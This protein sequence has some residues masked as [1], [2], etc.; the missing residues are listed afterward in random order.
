VENKKQRLLYIDNIRLLVIA[1]VVVLHIAVTYSG[2][3][4]WYYQEGKPIGFIAQTLFGFF[5]SLTQGYFMGLLFL[6]AGYFVPGAYDRKGFGRFIGDRL[7]RLGLPVLLYMLFIHPLT[8][9]VILG[10]HVAGE[11]LW[12]WYAIYIRSLDFIQGSGPLWFAL[13]LLIFTVLYGIVRLIA[14]KRL[15]FAS[16]IKAG[17]GL[18]SLAALMLIIAVFAFLIRIKQ[19]IGTNVLNMQLCYFAQY[20]VLFIVGILAYRQ[21]LFS[22]LD[23]KMGMR[24]LRS[25]LT[26]GFAAWGILMILGGGSRGDMNALNGGITWQSALFCL[27]ESFTAVAMD[28]GLI[29]LFREKCN[30]Q[31]GIVKPL[32]DSAFAVYVF[33]APII[34]ALSLLFRPVTWLPG[35]KFFAMIAVCVPVC[36][37]V[38]WLLKKVPLLKKIL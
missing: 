21:D 17:T 13:A 24:L 36:F 33:H 28:V 19:S 29:V 27:W 3:G 9:Y 1:L 8:T 26:W 20:I 6:I 31:S 10:N 5:Q 34:V 16:R 4:G 12:A 18:K 30:S 35:F 22:K 15:S 7:I 25:A 38:A 14:G 2:Y 11:S 32:S 23:Y 37:G